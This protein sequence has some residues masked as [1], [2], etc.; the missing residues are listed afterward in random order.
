MKRLLIK[1]LCASLCVTTLCGCTAFEKENTKTSSVKEDVDKNVTKKEKNN[2]EEDNR[3]KA[4]DSKET[5]EKNTVIEQT[6]DTMDSAMII[7]LNTKV[8]DSISGGK[9]KWYSFTTGDKK[10]TI[11]NISVVNDTPLSTSIDI[12]ILNQDG[13]SVENIMQPNADSWGGPATISMENLEA[14]TRYYVRMNLSESEDMVDYSIIIKDPSN[15][16]S[17]YKTSNDLF[18]LK[19]SV[20]GVTA[21]TSI[22]N[23]LL[24]PFDMKVT[25][26]VKMITRRANGYER[27]ESSTAWFAFTTG[28]NRENTYDVTLENNTSYDKGNAVRATIIDEYG[29]IEKI[30][31]A[32]I[33]NEEST[34]DS[35]TETLKKLDENTTYYIG[36]TGIAEKDSDFSLLVH[37]SEQEKTKESLV[38]KVP[39]EMNETQIQFV[40]NQAEFIDKNKAVEVLKP[41]AE[42]V[43]AY[44]DH[45]ILIAGTTAT[46][47]TQENCVE[48]SVRRAEAVKDVLVHHYNVPENQIQIVG[49]GYEKDPFERGKDRDQNGD[50]VES[51]GK[52]NRRVVVLDIEDP[53]AQ[54]ILSQK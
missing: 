10:D 48:L 28:E 33:F 19:K 34:S 31:H 22:N 20:D 39:F 40:I 38:F 41:V 50:F 27:E 24:L 30:L 52:K 7:P 23:A 16:T 37:S 45:S 8:F 11:Y 14:G 18:N 4:K 6:G 3:E 47:G 43:L 2:T 36:V 5:I 1:I 54:N 29:E 13:E 46:D 49:L 26:S 9:E 44:P 12:D 21:G 17:A 32:H 51:E 35:T 15:K 53:I 25:S 42:A